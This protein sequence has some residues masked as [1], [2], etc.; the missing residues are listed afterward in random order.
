MTPHTRRN[1]WYRSFAAEHGIEA[2]S[3]LEDLLERDIDGVLISTPHSTHRPLIEAAAEAG[4]TCV[5]RSR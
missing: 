4:S 3:T 2:A 1:S 5:W